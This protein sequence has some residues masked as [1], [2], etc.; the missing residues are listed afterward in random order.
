[1]SWSTSEMPDCKTARVFTGGV[2][3]I[4]GLKAWVNATRG[5]Q[6]FQ[7]NLTL[8]MALRGSR[9]RNLCRAVVLATTWIAWQSGSPLCKGGGSRPACQP[10]W[11]KQ[12]VAM[13]RS[14]VQNL[15][16]Q[17]NSK[18]PKFCSDV[19]NVLPWIN[20]KF[21]LKVWM[22][23]LWSLGQWSQTLLSIHVV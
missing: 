1:M 2:T 9:Y 14:S 22:S 20:W 6:E 21:G 10:Q 18:R 13:R 16:K 19:M 8:Q 7:L 3:F 23:N 12:C 5:L 17:T 4:W 11:T 15:R